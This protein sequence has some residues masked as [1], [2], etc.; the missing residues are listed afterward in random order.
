MKKKLKGFLFIALNVFLM[1]SMF[2]QSINAIPTGGKVK[3]TEEN[4]VSDTSENENSLLKKEV[5][6]TFDDGPSC[7]ITDEVLNILKENDVKATF[8]L[9]GNQIE[10]REEVVK[11]INDE[12]HSIGLHTFNHKYKCVYASEDKFI[13]EMNQCREEINRVIGISPSII[14][15]PGGSYKHLNKKYLKRLHDNNLK[16]YDW[17]V[18]S[19]DGMNPNLSPDKIY[20]KAIKI[21]KDLQ[22]TIVLMHCTDLQKNTPKALPEIIKYYK[23]QGYEF[24]TIDEDTKEVYFRLS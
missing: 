14:R 9:I 20:R 4:E 24:K 8:F 13:E 3:N 17:N 10:G 12:G 18:D 11:R 23:E 22:P 2:S 7:K 16:V 1:V 15:F 6:L 21:N 5:Y 19:T